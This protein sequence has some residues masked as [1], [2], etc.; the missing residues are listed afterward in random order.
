MHV[1]QNGL[2]VSGKISINPTVAPPVRYLS[3]VDR[4]LESGLQRFWELEAVDHGPMYSVQEKQCEEIYSNTTTR[5]H[6]GRY[7]VRLPHSDDPQVTLGKSQQ[8]ATRCFYS[9]ERRLER[10][11]ALKSSYHEFIEEYLCLGHMRKLESVDDESPHC[12]LPHHP[13]FKE[14]STTT[15][16][17]VVFDASCKIS[18]GMFPNDTLLVGPVV[19]QNLDSIVNRF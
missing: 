2:R 3:T 9:L 10:D 18:S 1:Q 15:K 5:T 16:V 6:D 4:T 7:V 11:A 14:S 19:Q 17:R 13:V 12:Y 8:I